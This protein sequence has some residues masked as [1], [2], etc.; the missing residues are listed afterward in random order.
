MEGEEGE[1]VEEKEG[2]DEE[3]EEGGGEEGEEG[4]CGARR[5][6]KERR[7]KKGRTERR[8]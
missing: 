6:V 2:E 8:G 3:G 1:K 7:E 4:G 5:G